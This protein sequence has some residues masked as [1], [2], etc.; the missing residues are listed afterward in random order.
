MKDKQTTVIDFSGNAKNAAL[1]FDSVIPISGS[2]IRED[3]LNFYHL[4]EFKTIFPLKMQEDE[5]FE[6]YID[7]LKTVR[8]SAISYNIQED[9]NGERTQIAWDLFLIN[10]A[11]FAGGALGIKEYIFLHNYNYDSNCTTSYESISLELSQL[12]LIDTDKSEWEQII[13]I[14]EDVESLRKLKKLRLFFH[15]NYSS[16]DKNFIQDDLLTRIEEY[17]NTVKDWG[18]ETVT[19]SIT[20]LNTSITSVGSSLVLALTGQPLEVA[21]ASGICVG[22]GNIAIHLAK[23]KYKLMKF[24]RDHPLAYIIDAKKK[25][26]KE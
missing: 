15:E 19:S 10:L 11:L 20:L 18:F 22:I 4:E 14:R 2:F 3:A 17:N 26:E 13:K 8:N 21:A 23:E 7:F 12:Q 25:L 24:G 16:R 1:Y 9:T 5:G 6:G